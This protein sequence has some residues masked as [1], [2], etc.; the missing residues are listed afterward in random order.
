MG[1]IGGSILQAQKG[2]QYILEYWRTIDFPGVSEFNQESEEPLQGVKIIVTEVLEF[3]DIN[4]PNLMP[5]Y[6]AIWSIG[7]RGGISPP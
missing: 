6:G 1:D 4:G 3:R 5:K 7:S 2:K